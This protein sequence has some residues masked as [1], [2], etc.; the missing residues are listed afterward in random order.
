MLFCV[1]ERCVE[2]AGGG[3][4]GDRGQHALSA[5]ALLRNRL[6]SACKHSELEVLLGRGICDIVLAKT[7][8]PCY[9]SSWSSM[10]V[11][12]RS[13]ATSSAASFSCACSVSAFAVPLTA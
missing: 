6:L 11:S 13:F 10:E 12:F 1:E 4:V 8:M 3:R 5:T 2:G 9:D 7:L